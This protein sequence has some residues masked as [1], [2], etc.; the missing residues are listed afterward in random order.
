MF[1]YSAAASRII[2]PLA[3]AV[4]VMGERKASS[5]AFTGRINAATI[6]GYA[7]A[8]LIIAGMMADGTWSTGKKSGGSTSMH[9]KNAILAEAEARKVNE[10]RAKRLVEKAAAI[11]NGRKAVPGVLDAAGKGDGSVTSIV[12]AL[13]KA[14][15]T[16]EAQLLRHVDGAPAKDPVAIILKMVA[17]LDAKQRAHLDAELAKPATDDTDTAPAEVV[18]AAARGRGRAP[19]SVAVHSAA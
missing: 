15:I 11:L 14:K 10:A 13:D 9:L 2:A 3:V 1:D 8:A 7:T 19:G 16:T 18:I 4:D 5:V 17:N 6:T 12:N